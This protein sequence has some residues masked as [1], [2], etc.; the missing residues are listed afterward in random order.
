MC[1]GQAAGSVLL[2]E[3]EHD[4][5]RYE[6]RLAG[7]ASFETS[8]RRLAMLAEAARRAQMEMQAMW[9]IGRHLPDNFPL[10]VL[11]HESKMPIAVRDIVEARTMRGKTDLLDVHPANA[12]RLRRAR[13]ANE[14][15]VL[16]CDGPASALFSD[17]NGLAR[18]AT[19]AYYVQGL[20]F[21]VESANLRKLEA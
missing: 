11:Q 4:A 18:Q 19:F 8:T 15:G 2:R 20:G 16:R 21:D 10:L 7:S 17:F 5:D 1:P 12:E 9:R 3:M 6:M 14:P 13:A